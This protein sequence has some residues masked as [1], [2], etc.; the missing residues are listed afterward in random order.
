MRKGT[1]VVVAAAV[2]AVGIATVAATASARSGGV[3]G[4]QALIAKYSK[5]P[6]FVPP[7]AAFNAKKLLRGKKVM[8][9]PVTSQLPITQTI[10]ASMTAAA[11]RVGVPFT[12]W[13]NQGKSDQWI[14]GIN[15][16]I[17]QH[18][19]V[20]DLL[21]IPPAVLRPQIELAHKAG[22]KVITSHF[23]GFGWTPPSYVDGAVRLPYYQVGQIL[24]A[25]AIVQTKGKA[26]IF[27]VVADDLVST[28]D[29][30]KGMND[31]LKRDCPACKIKLVSVPTVEWA[32][33]VQ[34]E[35][36]S[37]LQADPKINFVLPIYDAM[38]QFV[39]A[40]L[41]TTGR[42]ARVPQASFNGSTFALSFVKQGTVQ[43]DIGE[44]ED[45]I[46]HAMLD[47]DMRAA[48]GLKVPSNDYAGTPLYIF[49]KKNV[50]KAGTPPNPA[51]GYGNAY[52]GGFAKLWG[53]R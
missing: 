19:S 35:V 15:A 17:A 37:G 36:Q 2:A 41:R 23:A 29:V 45:W 25:W 42:S 5:Q 33:K 43:M 47:A 20:I 48:A 21:A 22:I 3:A 9:I 24:A 26:D 40:A 28:A 52:L 12:A 1:Y 13:Q 11:K 44:N 30:E 14:A 49:T 18:Y 8:L 51:K 4:A 46:A 16:A 10:T 39:A 27:S 31:E 38:T 53:G 6:R 7:G 32:D 50:A 34:G